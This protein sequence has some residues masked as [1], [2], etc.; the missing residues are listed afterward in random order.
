MF[1][2]NVRGAGA[3]VGYLPD[4]RAWPHSPPLICVRGASQ[5]VA[6]RPAT[7]RTVR[8]GRIVSDTAGDILSNVPAGLLPPRFALSLEGGAHEI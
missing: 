4:R 5:R 7:E 2:E 8:R 3:F 1:S 6:V